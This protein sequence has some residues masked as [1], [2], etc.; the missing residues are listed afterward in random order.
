MQTVCRSIASPIG[1]L[2]LIQ[3]DE[4]LTE[5]RF[6]PSASRAI[7][8]GNS[9]LLKEAEAQLTA[10]FGGRLT[11]F[12]LPL[13]LEGTPFRQECWAALRRIPYGEV[14]TYAQQAQMIQRPGAARAVGMAN[15]HNP[16]PIFIPC[17]RIIG[18]NG[19]LTGYA[20]GLWRKQWLLELEKRTIRAKDALTDPLST[21]E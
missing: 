2:S 14:R 10:Y 5:L 12:D 9:P 15:H 3:Q 17:H 18:A 6:E 4:C 8:Q 11:A 20:G 16:L 19:A 13:R 21:K 1:M 7:Q